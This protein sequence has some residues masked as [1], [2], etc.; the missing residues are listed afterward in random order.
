MHSRPISHMHLLSRLLIAVLLLVS[1]GIP[2]S[3][4]MAA[5]GMIASELAGP[6][7]VARMDD[8]Q[9]VC[10]EPVAAEAAC[11]AGCSA[12][13][14]ATPLIPGLE[15]ALSAS[16]NAVAAPPA[17]RFLRSHRPELETPPPRA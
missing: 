5:S 13:T 16:R 6:S 1:A 3:P 2:P 10:C 4:G 9:H 11:I 7:T 12:V 8:H 14:C 17:M 15:A